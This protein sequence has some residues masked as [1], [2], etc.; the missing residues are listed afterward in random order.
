MGYI[1]L[2]ME[3]AGTCSDTGKLCICSDEKKREC[4]KLIN[5]KI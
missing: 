4:E 5:N 2:N 1:F 3:L